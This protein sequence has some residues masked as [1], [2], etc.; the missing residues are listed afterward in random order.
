MAKLND[1]VRSVAASHQ[2]LISDRF[3]AVQP[4]LHKYQHPCDVHYTYEGY[5]VLAR[6]DWEVAANALGIS[7]IH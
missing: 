1:V 7:E 4:E 2:V 3:A 6:V 5:Q